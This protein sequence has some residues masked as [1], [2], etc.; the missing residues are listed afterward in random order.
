MIIEEPDGRVLR[1]DGREFREGDFILVGQFHYSGAETPQWSIVTR[2]AP[3]SASV[4]PIKYAVAGHDQHEGQC[5][6]D[7]VLEHR[8]KPIPPLLDVLW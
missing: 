8:P 4:Y 3:G 7:E 2:I 1:E 6:P 5:K